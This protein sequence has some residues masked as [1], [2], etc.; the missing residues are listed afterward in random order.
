MVNAALLVACTTIP[1]GGVPARLVSSLTTGANITRWFCYLGPGDQ[2]S[3]FDNYLVQADYDAFSQLGYKFVRLCIS[4][5]AIYIQGDFVPATMSS[6]DTAVYSLVSHGLT[7]IWDLHD[8]GQLK[9][10]QPGADRKGFVNFWSKVA[11]HYRG[12]NEDRVVFELLNEPQFQK[13]S[14]DW[15]TLQ[16]SAV[17]AIRAADPKR[18]ILVSGT[19]W[20]G[21]E[22]L[23]AM[24]PLPEK[25]LVYTFHCYDPF[26]F[27]HQGAEWVGEYP[28]KFQQVPFPS[29]PEAVSKILPM[30]DPK[31][32]GTLQDYGNHHYDA[33]YLQDRIAKGMNWGEANHV[34]VVLGEFGAYPKVSP[35]DSRARWFEAMRMA[36]DQ[37]HAPNAIWGYDDGLGLGRTADPDGTIHLDPIALRSFYH[38]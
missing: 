28:Q 34:P 12:V 15:Y 4:P 10:D 32:A 19:S 33:A 9:L 7:V 27:T 37:L 1:S 20:S 29:S 5:D 30:N 16:E 22:T 17:Q 35:P 38:Q 11:A 36:I 14:D 18:T 26:F 8:N 31:Y 25:N 2:K 13:N 21:I 6:V 23:V 24:K 3:H